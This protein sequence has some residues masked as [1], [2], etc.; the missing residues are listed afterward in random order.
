LVIVRHSPLTLWHLLSLDAPTVAALWTWFVARCCGIALPPASVAAMFLAVWILY[1]A[2]R[3]LDARGNTSGLEERHHFHHRHRRLFIPFVAVAAVALA[4]LTPG[5]SVTALRIY[6]LLAALLAGWFLIIHTRL[7]HERRL[8]KELAVGLFFSAAIFIPTVARRP[9]LRLSLLAPAFVFAA[10]CALNCM[11][12]YR[13]EHPRDRTNA[14]WTTRIAT[15]HL[16]LAAAIILVAAFAGIALPAFPELASRL[17]PVAPTTWP[18]A[19][20]CVVSSLLLL[21]LNRSRAKISPL[22][23]RAAADLALLT[24]ILFVRF[25]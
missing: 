14:N 23:L 21:T 9:D 3:L 22:N 10:V 4:A 11:Y 12:L 20:A 19:A 13:W 17:L 25:R 18:I 16:T 8:P 5:L 24:P 2:D 7:A 1:A 15:H 6:A